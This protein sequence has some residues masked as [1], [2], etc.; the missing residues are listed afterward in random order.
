MKKQL[1]DLILIAAIII[2]V[3]GLVTGRYLFLFLAI[4]IGFGWFGSKN[5]SGK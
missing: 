3:Y 5:K 4:P 1:Y 2:T